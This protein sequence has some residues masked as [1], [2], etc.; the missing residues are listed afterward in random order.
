MDK[1]VLGID[2]GSKGFLALSVNDSWE[3]YAISEYDL[4]GLANIISKIKERCDESGVKLVCVMEEIHAIFGSSA[5]ATFSFGEIFGKL[6]GIIVANKISL[7][8]VQPKIWQK[9]MWANSD[10]VINYKKIVIKGKETVRKEVDTKNTS[11]NAARRIFPEID[12]RRSVRCTNFDDNKVDAT[13]IAEY[14]RRN[15]L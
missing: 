10:M 1:A 4:L 8:F 13:L 12:F 3:Y 14:G 6:Q 2:V 15:N 5:K 11:Y 7:H 9:Q